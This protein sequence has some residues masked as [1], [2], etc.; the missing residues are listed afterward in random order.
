MKLIL[1]IGQQKTG[2]TSLQRFL[3]D[4]R[5]QLLQHKILYPRSLGTEHYKQHLIFKHRNNLLDNEL[6]LYKKLKEEII[7]SKAETVIISDE[8][9]FFG[10][11][12]KKEEIVTF[13]K[14]LFDEIEVLVYLRRQDLHAPSHYQQAQLSQV[15]RT[16]DEWIEHAIASGYYDYYNVLEDWRKH[17]SKSEFIIKPLGNSV[18]KDVRY[19]ILHTLGLDYQLFELKKSQQLNESVDWN[20][21]PILRCFNLLIKEKE[22]ERLR[23]QINQI[24]T[25][26]IKYAISISENDKLSLNKSQYEKITSYYEDVNEKLILHFDITSENKVYFRKPKYPKKISTYDLEKHTILEFNILADFIRFAFPKLDSEGQLLGSFSKIREYDF[27]EEDEELE[28]KHKELKDYTE[29]IVNVY[30]DNLERMK[31]EINVY[32]PK[33]LTERTLYFLHIA[34]CGGTSVRDYLDQLFKQGEFVG[35]LNPEMLAQYSKSEIKNWKLISGHLDRTIL[36]YIEPDLTITWLRNP[37]DRFVSAY[38]R[39]SELTIENR[40][41]FKKNNQAEIIASNFE[42][43]SNYFRKDNP[44]FLRN[45]NLMTKSLGSN[46]FSYERYT[47]SGEDKLNEAKRFLNHDIYFFGIMDRMQESMDLLSYA[48]GQIPQNSYLHSNKTKSKYKENYKSQEHLDFFNEISKLDK[49]LWQYAIDLF[50]ERFN[51]TLHYLWHKYEGYTNAL[52][53]NTNF[54]DVDYKSIRQELITF[55]KKEIE[56]T[57][58]IS[59]VD[60]IEYTFDLPLHGDGWSKR[61]W[62]NDLTHYTLRWIQK[63]TASIYFP[64]ERSNLLEC[65]MHI[66]HYVTALKTIYIDGNEV[67]DLIYLETDNHTKDNY[68]GNLVKFTIPVSLETK[69]FF[70]KIEI[71]V[72]HVTSPNELDKENPDMQLKSISV[73]WIKISP[74]P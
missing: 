64:L 27:V 10:R 71:E 12:T 9:L 57:T 52:T 26:F 61:E 34:K 28:F 15:I 49:E 5:T 31:S 39:L 4:N 1:H 45:G 16:F 48:T 24:K 35:G 60:S 20:M 30:Q 66:P 42:N 2:S 6:N 22:D 43:D 7:A 73:D 54:N 46:F 50:N 38:G 67:T 47:K 36:K 51:K 33:S 70:T 62:Y 40:E 41:D 72:T 63:P 65:H 29:S 13:L 37:I 17:L 58:E 23:L 21:I 3:F 53:T 69:P 18:K 32:K 68:M 59:Q 56:S 11:S 44:E 55:M 14:S 8:N 19:D 25:H 74:L